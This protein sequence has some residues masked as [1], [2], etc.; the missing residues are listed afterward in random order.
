MVRSPDLLQDGDRSVDVFRCF[1]VAVLSGIELGQESV[2]IESHG[3][4]AFHLGE[5]SFSV[6]DE[7]FDLV[8][9][10]RR[11]QR[12]NQVENPAQLVVVDRR[13]RSGP[14]AL[15]A[16][17]PRLLELAQRLDP[18]SAV[19]QNKLERARA[20]LGSSGKP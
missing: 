15:R 4:V 10:P 17:D 1:I 3:I 2:V 20:A 7:A 5:P 9:V 8:P 12:D 14:R 19:I 6:G 16:G 13:L 11:R 18:D